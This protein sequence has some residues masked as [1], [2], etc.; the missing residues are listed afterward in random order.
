MFFMNILDFMK[1][2]HCIKSNLMKAFLSLDYKMYYLFPILQ[3][4]DLTG[5]DFFHVDSDP[6]YCFD[7]KNY[8]TVRQLFQKMTRMELGKE[9][10][11]KSIMIIVNGSLN[12]GSQKS[13]VSLMFEL[14]LRVNILLHLPRFTLSNHWRINEGWI[15]W[16][17]PA[18]FSLLLDSE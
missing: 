7:L 17:L 16:L 6:F 5:W 4:E 10:C 11:I 12:A 3:I 1:R 18:W 15:H 9:L 13:V 8:F 14:R 2:P